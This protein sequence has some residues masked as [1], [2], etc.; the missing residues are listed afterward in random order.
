MQHPQELAFEM[1]VQGAEKAMQQAA[2]EAEWTLTHVPSWLGYVKMPAGASA[3]AANQATAAALAKCLH[4]Q[5]AD[6]RYT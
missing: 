4:E 3:A 2:Q 1:R 5:T 6:F